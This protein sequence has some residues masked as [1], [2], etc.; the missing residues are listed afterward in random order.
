MIA[1]DYRRS[2]CR[3]RPGTCCFAFAVDVGAVAAGRHSMTRMVA[4]WRRWDHST[5]KRAAVVGDLNEVEAAWTRGEGMASGVV[6]DLQS[7]Q[8]GDRS[9]RRLARSSPAS[10]L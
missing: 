10:K 6:M 9:A 4:C 2:T 7:F 3:L 5:G 1:R 8:V